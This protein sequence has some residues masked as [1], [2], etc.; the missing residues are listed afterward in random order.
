MQ[1]FIIKNDDLRAISQVQFIEQVGDIIANRAFA[2]KERLRNLLI[3][4]AFGKQFDDVQFTFGDI[5]IL[6]GFF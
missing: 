5:K 2:E 1:V 3:V 4:H 6:N